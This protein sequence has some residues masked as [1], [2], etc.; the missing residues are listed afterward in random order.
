MMR[1]FAKTHA[2]DQPKPA[3]HSYSLTT[4]VSDVSWIFPLGQL[5]AYDAVN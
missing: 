4:S 5:S 3:V 2:R 1:S